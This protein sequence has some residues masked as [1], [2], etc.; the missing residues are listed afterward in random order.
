MKKLIISS[1]VLFSFLVYA[2]SKSS[3]DVI[4]NPPPGGNTCDTANMK[5][6]ANIVPILQANCYT[7]HGTNTNSGSMGIILEGHNNIVSR[8][9]D[10]TLLAVITHAS[11]FPPMPQAGAKLSDCNINKIRSWINHGAQNN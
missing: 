7:C 10:G 4:N 11:G 1:I 6:Q 5:Y 9:T 2:C 3:E 8:A